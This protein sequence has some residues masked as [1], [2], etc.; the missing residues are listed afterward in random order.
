MRR[1]FKDQRFKLYF[2]DSLV[3]IDISRP[4]NWVTDLNQNSLVVAARGGAITT[5]GAM[6]SSLNFDA[7]GGGHSF[8]DYQ[9][10][11]KYSSMPR[12][13]WILNR[14]DEF[15]TRIDEV[16]KHAE[17][18]VTRTLLVLSYCID[19]SAIVNLPSEKILHIKEGGVELAVEFLLSNFVFHS[20]S[21]WTDSSG[22]VYEND[23]AFSLYGPDPTIYSRKVE[24][25]F[26]LANDLSN[27]EEAEYDID[28]Y[29]FR[30][31]R[32]DYFTYGINH[33]CKDYLNDLIDIPYRVY[34]ILNQEQKNI[35][36]SQVPEILAGESDYVGIKLFGQ[37][38]DDYKSCKDFDYKMNASRAWNASMYD[39]LGGDGDSDVY[40][41]DGVSISRDGNLN[42]G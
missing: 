25:D 27:I 33:A 30:Y 38:F 5:G 6:M 41:G 18:N 11:L 15:I 24:I 2:C 39:V 1:F 7:E 17:S 29:G 13:E 4:E 36:S 34:K 8:L 31:K 22:Q 37:N 21:I 26:S 3:G 28:D 32:E 42:E 16:I 20:K 40:L 35:L 9:D 10:Y 19:D 23:D 14:S 12:S